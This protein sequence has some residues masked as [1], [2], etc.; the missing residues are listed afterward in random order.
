MALWIFTL[1]L[2]TILADAA[3]FQVKD[4]ELQRHRRRA[5]D[6]PVESAAVPQPARN[7]RKRAVP[8][9]VVQVD[10][11]SLTTST[12]PPPAPTITVTQPG[13]TPTPSTQTILITSVVTG[14]A[15]NQTVIVTTTTDISETVTASD[16]SV[17]VT[18][19]LN[20][21]P[22]VPPT[23]TVVSVTTATPTDYTSTILNTVMDT[24]TQTPPSSPTAYYDNGLWH[25][26]YPV[27]T[28]VPSDLAGTLNTVNARAAQPT[29]P[30]S[31]SDDHPILQD[32][33]NNSKKM[34][35]K[36]RRAILEGAAEGRQSSKSGYLSASSTPIS[37]APTPI[38]QLGYARRNEVPYIPENPGY[39]HLQVRKAPADLKLAS[40]NITRTEMR[41]V[42]RF[43][44]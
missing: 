41:G 9:S 28:F 3:P 26:Y 35:A 10:G 32:R 6:Y 38:A 18:T 17:T 19:V 2:L 22:V 1:S 40:Y 4:G 39:S 12:P 29:L 33:T 34:S 44:S 24:V 14:P 15:S 30:A 21:S 31:V 20:A 25:T 5:V 11:G 23:S 36:Q 13:S 42:Q 43:R 27:K 37:Y 16:A 7:L 8:Y